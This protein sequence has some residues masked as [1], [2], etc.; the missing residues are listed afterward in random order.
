MIL[1]VLCSVILLPIQIYCVLP[2]VDLGADDGETL[3]H[4]MMNA[5]PLLSR[6]HTRRSPNPPENYSIN[7]LA[8][9]Y[10]AWKILNAHHIPI[11]CD[12]FGNSKEERWIIGGFR[13]SFW[14]I[15]F[16]KFFRRTSDPN[17]VF[18][19]EIPIAQEYSGIK[20]W[21]TFNLSGRR[22]VPLYAEEPSFVMR[23]EKDQ[24][25]EFSEYFN[26]SNWF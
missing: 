19:G 5:I 17:S 16:H 12:L 15:I 4:V 7:Q 9:Q 1:F 3:Q 13:E 22:Q 18:L 10:L 6:P 20:L 21:N 24:R 25:K 14:R 8:K 11:P 23:R 2:S 26:A